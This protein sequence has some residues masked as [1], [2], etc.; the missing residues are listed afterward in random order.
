MKEIK[1]R[2]ETTTEVPGFSIG[3]NDEVMLIGSCFTENMGTVMQELGFRVMVNPFGI[4]YNP[5]SIATALSMCLDCRPVGE[6]MLVRNEERWHSWL[7]H[8]SF[9][10]VDRQVCLDACNDAIREGYE[11][12]QR[13]NRLIV[14]FG[15]AWHYR[16]LN[17]GSPFVVANCH[18]VAAGR[19]EKR[20]A[21]VQEIVDVWVPLM[22]RLEEKDIKVVFT[23]S[24]VRHSAYG[25]HGNQLGK[26]VL[27]LS[28]EQLLEMFERCRY[29]PSYEIV[30]D[31]LRDYRY[32][33]DDM[34][35]PSPLAERIVW[36]RFQ[37]T[38]MTA[39]TI[40]CCDEAEKANKRA[41]H[42]KLAK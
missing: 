39:E 7:H 6:E 36:Q 15:S 14:T 41:R 31:E 4:L 22:K 27:L 26:A 38:Y 19:F 25:S 3:F 9:S 1:L 34:N 16:L 24:P 40:V 33:T 13:C 23:V 42:R 10:R 18:K 21:T 32:Y 2:T 17:D 28:I 30:V 37:E 29:F 8:G 20:L 35:H 5:L 11:F 12:L